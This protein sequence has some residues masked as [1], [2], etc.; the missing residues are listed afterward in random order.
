MGLKIICLIYMY[1]MDL[2]LNNLQCHKTQLNQTK[3][4]TSCGRGHT[5]ITKYKHAQQNVKIFCFITSEKCDT[6][7]GIGCM[8]VCGCQSDDPF[9][10]L[11][12]RS[13]TRT[14]EDE[15]RKV[16]EKREGQS[17]EEK[18]AVS[19]REQG[20]EQGS[21][22]KSERQLLAPVDSG[23]VDQRKKMSQHS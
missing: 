3:L 9:V 1:K 17:T 21:Q 15:V 12:A 8:G 10:C 13:P 23:W 5:K 16:P 7:L 18:K 2:A 14:E 22:Q 6:R 4:N 11:G 20:R 19:R